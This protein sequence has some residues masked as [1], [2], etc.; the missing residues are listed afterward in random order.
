MTY[1]DTRDRRLGAFTLTAAPLAIGGLVLLPIALVTE[2]ASRLDL[3]AAAVVLLPA[4]VNSALVYIL[5]NHVLQ[6]L[7]A[8]KVSALASHSPLVT[9]I[10]AW[11]L[12]AESLSAPQVVGM[13]IMV[14]G[15]L[16]IQLTR[17]LRLSGA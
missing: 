2:G 11:L 9:A 6:A 17:Q 10:G 5:Y 16:L 3:S 13:V 14:S 7:A 1:P 15:V 4:I 8:F 12:L